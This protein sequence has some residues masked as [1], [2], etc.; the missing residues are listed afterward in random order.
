MLNG[1]PR[2]QL[3]QI[4]QVYGESCTIIAI[5]SV[6]ARMDGSDDYFYLVEGISSGWYASTNQNWSVLDSIHP[7]MNGYITLDGS[8]QYLTVDSEMLQNEGNPPYQPVAPQGAA[9]SHM[10][11]VMADML[12]KK[13]EGEGLLSRAKVDYPVGTKYKSVTDGTEQEVKSHFNITT[14]NMITDGHGGFVYAHNQWAEII[15]KKSLADQQLELIEEVKNRYPIGTIVKP[16]DSGDPYIIED[17]G[18]LGIDKQLTV[19][20]R[21]GNDF[22]KY[23]TLTIGGKEWAEEGRLSDIDIHEKYSESGTLIIHDDIVHNH[24]E[25]WIFMDGKF[26]GAIGVNIES[27]EM[28]PTQ[29]I[30]KVKFMPAPLRNVKHEK[31]EDICRGDMHVGSGVFGD[32]SGAVALNGLGSFA[33]SDPWHHDESRKGIDFVLPDEEEEIELD[34]SIEREEEQHMEIFNEIHNLEKDE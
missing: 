22:L 15:P 14:D 16:I 27:V 7:L 28:I 10:D 21:Y 3:G 4:V 30:A 12:A 2:Y 13:A 29:N 9:S 18:N 8:K 17:H 6:C 32:K 24:K 25:D 34:L 26:L 11:P 5:E 19:I 20:Y 33:G 23:H 31:V 1:Q